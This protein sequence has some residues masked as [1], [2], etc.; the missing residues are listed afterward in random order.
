MTSPPTSEILKCC[1][2]GRELTAER[3]LPHNGGDYCLECAGTALKE[4]EFRRQGFS[5]S[6]GLAAFLSLIPGLGQMYNRQLTKG[7]ILLIVFFALCDGSGQHQ[8]YGLFIPVL[9]LW[10]MFDAYWMARRI[11]EGGAPLP[12]PLENH[13]LEMELRWESA[14]T[15]AWGVLLIVLGILFLLNNFGV[16]WLTYELLW[17]AALLVIG[18]WL[19]Y[20]FAVSSKPKTNEQESD[21]G[22]N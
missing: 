13:R 10:N 9:I 21:H 7:V 3:R 17:P 16:T 6:P 18:L 12:L 5:R 11:N 19:L 15:P 20:T 14:T 8:G 4:A 2:C 22:E 1:L